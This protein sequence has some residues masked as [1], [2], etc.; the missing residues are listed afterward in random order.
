MGYGFVCSSIKVQFEL[1]FRV[2]YEH[3]SLSSLFSAS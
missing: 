1:I 3:L 2:S